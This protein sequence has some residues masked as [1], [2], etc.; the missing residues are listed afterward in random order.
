MKC[1]ISPYTPYKGKAQQ[2]DFYRDGV[3]VF[4]LIFTLE[5]FKIHY[6]N[7]EEVLFK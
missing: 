5:S 6:A 3:N 4:W 7:L 1:I 2:L